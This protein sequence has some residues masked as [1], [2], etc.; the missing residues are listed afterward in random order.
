MASAERQV[1]GT[2]AGAVVL[3]AVALDEIGP[4]RIFH[5][6]DPPSGLRA[7]VVIDTT[8]FGISGGGVRLAP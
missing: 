6:Y 3:G 2:A 7:V 1:G 5:Y 8:R 4:E